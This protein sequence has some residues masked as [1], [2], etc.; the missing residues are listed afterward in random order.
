L[1]RDVDGQTDLRTKQRCVNHQQF[2][3]NSFPA[4]HDVTSDTS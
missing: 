3:R 4:Y 1:S 2:S